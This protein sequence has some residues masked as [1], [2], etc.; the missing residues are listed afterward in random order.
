MRV[1][2]ALSS[3]L[4]LTACASLQPVESTLFQQNRYA[5][6]RDLME[7]RVQSRQTVP[8]ADYAYLCFAYAK[9]RQYDRLFPC[10]E[11]MQARIDGGD[12][13]LYWFDFSAEPALLRALAA[14]E[15]GDLPTAIAE[16]RTAYRLTEGKS[17][18]VQMRVYAIAL[19]G[20]A[21]AL[22]GERAAADRLITEL[23]A[24][25]LSYSESLI[26]SDKHI[27][28]ARIHMALGEHAAALAALRRDDAE[29][30]GLK[31]LVD[32]L[33]G[34]GLS[35]SS[36]F[37]YW[38]LPKQAMRAKALVE[39]GQHDAARTLLDRL[40]GERGIESNGDL[41]WLLLEL[42]ARIAERD[43]QRDTAIAL[44]REAAQQI[45]TQRST[46]AREA[47]RIGFVGD[48]QGVYLRLVTLLVAAGRPAE[49]FEAAERAKARALVDLLAGRDIRGGRDTR[50]Q[51]R[52]QLRDYASAAQAAATI[53]TA[54]PAAEV[55]QRRSTLI[56][57]RKRLQ[58]DAPATAALVTGATPTAAAIQAHLRSGEIL[59]EYFGDEVHLFGFVVSRQTLRA[60]R[61][62]GRGLAGD[63]SHLRTRVDTPDSGDPLPVA[64]Q[65]YARLITP[66][67]LPGGPM[68]LSI[69]PHGAMHYLPFAALHDGEAY[70]VERSPLRLLPAA[71]VLPF[72]VA[73]P[74]N[75]RGILV[76]GNPDL[77][78]PHLDIAYAGDEARAIA[79]LYPEATLLLRQQARE[80][81]FKRDAGKYRHLHLAVH[82]KFQPEA[83]LSS[84]LL[85]VGGDQEDGVLSAG[86][87]YDLTLDADLVTLSAC[88][89]GLGK[90]EGGDDVVGFTRGFLFAGARSLVAS[91]WSVDDR[92]TRD[93][94]VRFTRN[95][96][97]LAKD[98]ALRDAQLAVLH[99]YRHPF[100]WSAFQL[101]GD[102][103]ERPATTSGNLPVKQ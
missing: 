62:D 64:R 42:R 74:A 13:Q 38:E 20:L 26:A 96:G 98:E 88:E 2:V 92:A 11:R 7:A 72:V 91:L 102:A 5:E 81:N 100:Y 32:A 1:I 73:A 103:G 17:A 84:G 71:G 35:G 93:L 22:T 58:D 94:M 9:T 8:T 34:A 33:T 80:R 10:I 44:L 76:M 75:T 14:L 60:V 41:Y 82:G 57:M 61:L 68:R 86:E 65:L 25:P 66:L 87:L 45:E 70:L 39:T 3:L 54:L 23:A 24:V 19:L 85:L 69:V 89:T 28:I 97:H 15:F 6:L 48:K 30:G 37:A 12:R 59:I 53:D 52:E 77:G 46:I 67:E 56:D 36:I 16:G 50:P 27:G 40:L 55:A 47:A 51:L 78:A 21:H 99:Q 49:A 90:V 79:A 63:I 101:T 29:T 18:Y 43:G 31:S 4:V 83:P 95:L